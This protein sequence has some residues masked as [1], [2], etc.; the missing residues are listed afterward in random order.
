MR[1]AGLRIA[2]DDF[3]N[4]YSSMAS[5]QR[6]PVDILKIDRSFTLGPAPD[7]APAEPA[8]VQAILGLAAALSLDVI[9]EGVETADQRAA[10]SALGCRT[11]Q[12]YLF[13]RPTPA[14]SIDGLLAAERRGQTSQGLVSNGTGSA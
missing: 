10:L 13:A 1:T 7:S 12:G 9:A 14:A 6:L 11:A 4:G 3:G 2:V 8:F 5:L